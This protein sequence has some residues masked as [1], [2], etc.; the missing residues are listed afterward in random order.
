MILVTGG[1]GFI[2]LHVTR[3]LLDLGEQVVITRYRTTRLPSFLADF[4]GKGLTVIPLDLGDMAAVGAALREHKINSIVHL[5]V[6][7]RTNLSPIEEIIGSTRATLGL[8]SAAVEAGVARV[9]AAS[10]LAVYMSSV[11]AGSPREDMPLPLSAVHPIEANKK[12]DEVIEAFLTNSG[13]L[14]VIRARIGNIWGPCY[15]S[16]M[17]APSRLAMLA[18]GQEER[19]AGRPDP[20]NA[21]ADDLLDLLYVRDCGRALALLHT[22]AD[23]AH[24]VYNVSGGTMTRYADLADAIGQ[25]A[26][27]SLTLQQ[28]DRAP[29]GKAD[30]HMDISRL[31]QDTG[32]MPTFDLATATADYIA[33]LRTNPE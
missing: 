24:N 16:M 32:F 29:T 4:V 18:L 10:S 12:I 25:A 14:R 5:A 30:G 13:A 19:F 2:G 15:H 21:R 17:N 3:S 33:W 23:L 6:P 31:Q 20:L 1:M 7:P 26:G 9:T 8:M 27:S 22:Q 28:P 11:I